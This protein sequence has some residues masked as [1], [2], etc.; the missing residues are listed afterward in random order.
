MIFDIKKGRIS[1]LSEKLLSADKT[2]HQL[3]EQQYMQWVRS[4]CI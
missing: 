2:W 3:L 1:G 4:Q